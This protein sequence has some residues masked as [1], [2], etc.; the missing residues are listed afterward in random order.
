M[1]DRDLVERHLQRLTLAQSEIRLRLQEIV[2]DAPQDLGV[3]ES[4]NNPSRR[5]I[6]SITTIAIPWTSPVPAGVRGIIHV[7]AHN[8]PIK[9][10]RREALLIAIAKARQWMDDLAHGRVASFGVIAHR[11]GKGGTSGCWRRLP[12]FR[13]GSCQRFLTAPRRPTSPS[14]R[15]PACCPIPGPSRNAGSQLR[16]HF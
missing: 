10:G 3:H 2:E 14:Q 4:A 5:P 12:S 16:D 15:S 8:T 11:E 9:P 1:S 6:A 13:P 7:P